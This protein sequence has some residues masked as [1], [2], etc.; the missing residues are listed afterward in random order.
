MKSRFQS[1]VVSIVAI[2]S[3][4]ASAVEASDNSTTNAPPAVVTVKPLPGSHV[5][6]PVSQ[7]MKLAKSK[8]PDEVVL[9]YIENSPYV[10]ALTP[11]N[12]IYLNEQGISP[13]QIQAMLQHD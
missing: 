9:S 12:I 4:S 5:S 1:F 10:F 6:I 11:E 8:V 13:K 7:V 3:L 2:C